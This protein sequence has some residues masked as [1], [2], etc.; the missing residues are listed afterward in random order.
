MHF[1][2]FT[3][4][5]AALALG[6]CALLAQ[7]ADEAYPSRPVTIVVPYAPGGGSDAVARTIAK[8]L[9]AEWNQPVVVENRAGAEGWIGTQRVLSQP[10]DGYTVLLQLNSM[11]LWK[12]ALPEARI[13][14][15]RDL[16]LLT[17][18][19]SSPVV[20]LVGGSVAAS[21]LR[22]M[23]ALCGKRER[24]CSFGTSTASA[25]LV[26]RQLAEQG[27]LANAVIAPYKGTS[28]MVS[29]LLGGHIDIA[30]VSANQAAP[31]H[32]D[33]RGKAL[34]VGSPARFPKMP[35]VATFAEAGYT[36]GGSNT[37][38]GLM[39]RQDTPDAV[40]QKITAAVQRAGR[41]PE[42]LAAIATQGGVAV[43]NSPD[44]FSREFA[45]ELQAITPVAEK[46][47]K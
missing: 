3:R 21:S 44:E 42:V 30:L 32:A 2:R 37:W 4:H 22:D 36:I 7:A 23:M 24:P 8:E 1:P 19:Q 15:A 13:D 34:A 40:V 5:L 18:L 28:P 6:S 41:K 47:L 29:D 38:Y 31:L 33:G 35:N 10:A 14:F 11:L 45:A 26:G 27:G 12:W 43:F 25:Q 9:Q 39:V 16:R 20:A 17:K 46:F